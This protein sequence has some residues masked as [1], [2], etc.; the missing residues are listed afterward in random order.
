MTKFTLK[1]EEISRLKVFIDYTNKVKTLLAIN[2]KFLFNVENSGKLEIFALGGD[3]SSDSVQAE[4][5]VDITN[6]SID[7]NIKSHFVTELSSI[8][9][10]IDKFPP[11]EEILFSLFTQQQNLISSENKL[12]IS[13]LNTKSVFTTTLTNGKEDSEVAEIKK[14]ISEILNLPEFQNKIELDISNI[15]NELMVLADITKIFGN[16][17]KIKIDDKLLIADGL[18]IFSKSLAA[19]VCTEPTIIVNSELV[20]LFKNID[21][22]QISS[23]KKFWFFNYATFGIQLLLVPPINANSSGS[24]PLEND[25]K[26][27]LPL[28]TSRIKLEISAKDLFNALKEFEGLFNGWE[29]GSINL[30]VPADFDTKKELEF[31]WND[32][33]HQVVTSIPVSIVERTDTASDFEFIFSTRELPLIKDYIMKDE[34]TMFTME[35][36][37]TPL[38]DLHGSG[39]KLSNNSDVDIILPKMNHI[40]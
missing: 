34:N 31:N 12:V 11:T 18:G 26:D 2:D 17:K 20:K 30:N 27:L 32:E 35:F 22:I 9:T 7:P 28:D 6:L 15:E 4:I 16:N 33:L 10:I 37:S 36:S 1:R 40:T 39:V 19:K 3:G 38:G 8:L 24:F 21:K 13:S 29:Y 14:F 25:I 23:D 5:K